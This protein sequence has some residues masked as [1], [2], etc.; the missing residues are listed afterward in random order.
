MTCW[1][2]WVSRSLSV[3][4]RSANRCTASGS[5]AASLH[6]LGQQPDRADRRL[7]LVADVGDEVAAYGLDP[8]LAGAVLDQGEHQA[9]AERRDPR[10]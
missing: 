1:T 6:R 4:I 8:A 5:S 10:A 2:R 3:T 9:G 7:E